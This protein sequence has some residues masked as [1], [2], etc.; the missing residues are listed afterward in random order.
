MR[1]TISFCAALLLAI[2][3]AIPI[4]V[5][6][7]NKTFLVYNKTDNSIVRLYVAPRTASTWEDNVLANTTSVEPDT[8]K[9]IN[10]TSDTRDVSLYD[11]KAVF[12]DGTNV[13]AGKINLCRTRNVYIY[14]DR[15]TYTY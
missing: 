5:S 10:M 3:A 11:V 2:L 8:Y 4:S 7:C 13:S 9:R 12:D 15:V 6:A 14:A 1:L